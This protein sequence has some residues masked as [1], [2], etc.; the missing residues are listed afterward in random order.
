MSAHPNACHKAART[1]CKALRT[2][3]AYNA[4]DKGQPWS[5]PGVLRDGAW[6]FRNAPHDKMP[7]R[8]SQPRRDEG[9]EV[10]RK[11]MEAKH[12]RIKSDRREGIRDVHAEH[13]HP[14]DG[15]LLP[16]S[17]DGGARTPHRSPSQTAAAPH[18]KDPLRDI[19][20]NECD[21]FVLRRRSDARPRQGEPMRRV[22]WVVVCCANPGA[23]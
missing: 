13:Y 14:K 11:V 19:A 2:A 23:W 17:S 20:F 3:T 7:H 16:L 15:E 10:R 1:S 4:I 5:K 22:R 8:T 6:V 18:A 21:A 12:R 9:E